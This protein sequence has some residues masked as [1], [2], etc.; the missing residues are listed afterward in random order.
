MNMRPG[1]AARHG[2]LKS[3][4]RNARS[5]QVFDQ[6]SALGAVGMERDVNGIAV[7]EPHAIMGPGLPVG[8]DRQPMAEW[9]GSGPTILT[10]FFLTPAKPQAKMPSGVFF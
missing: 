2:V 3:D 5:A 1:G 4:K 7:V 6:S 8:A 10:N 9:L